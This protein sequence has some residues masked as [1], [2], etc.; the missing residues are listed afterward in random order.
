MSVPFFTLAL[1][2]AT[3]GL[4]PGGPGVAKADSPTDASFP[5][6]LPDG[7]LSFPAQYR[8]WIFL[9]SGLDMSYAEAGATAGSSM[10]DNVFVNPQA[11][12]E[13]ELT[14]TWPDHTLLV[15]ESRGGSTTG[16]I[17]KRGK[18]QTDD[19]MGVEVHIKDTQ[20]FTGGWAFFAFGDMQ[21]AQPIPSTESCY[22][23]HREHGAVDTT[24]VQFYPTLLPIARQKSTL[25]TGYKP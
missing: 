21:P 9:S 5:A 14:G 4:R 7:R 15:M 10:F 2:A 12:R 17:N 23:C 16:S 24:F 6:F 25:A 22:S 20:R 8:Q 3:L 1:L 18:F 13:F 19:F 11:Y